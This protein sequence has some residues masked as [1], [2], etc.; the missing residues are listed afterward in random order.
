[1]AKPML[2]LLTLLEVAAGAMSAAGCLLLF[3]RQRE[4]AFSGAAL[5]SLAILMLFAGMR[6]VRDYS[7][8]AG[9]VP[10]FVTCIAALVLLG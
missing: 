4:M 7:G 5:A 1:M 8:A 6:L 10:Y 3:G 9:I 2:T